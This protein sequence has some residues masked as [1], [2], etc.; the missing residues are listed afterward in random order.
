MRAT[1]PASEYC[2]A[3]GRTARSGRSSLRPRT[4]DPPSVTRRWS[5]SWSIR[6]ALQTSKSLLWWSNPSGTEQMTTTLVR[7][8]EHA[9][10]RLS[11][12]V[13]GQ[14]G[15]RID[16]AVRT[17]V[18]ASGRVVFGHR[19]WW[20]RRSGGHRR[21]RWRRP[22]RQLGDVLPRESG[23]RVALPVGS[24]VERDVLLVAFAHLDRRGAFT[25]H[26]RAGGIAS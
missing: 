23:V 14:I 18:C 1:S 2:G 25:G 9:L 11:L 10:P 8:H 5:V 12:P 7:G 17:H 13:L 6:G 19:Q 21:R 16:L 24:F 4:V 20:R 26:R 15:L 3:R 22:R